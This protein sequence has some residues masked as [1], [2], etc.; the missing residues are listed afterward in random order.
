M[1]RT[2]G[3]SNAAPAWSAISGK[4]AVFP[5]DTPIQRTRQQTNTSGLLTWTFPTPFG[6]G[7]VPVIGVAVES[8]STDSWG[9]VLKSVSNTAVTVQLTRTAAVTILGI[10]VLGIAA[11]PQAYVHLMAVAP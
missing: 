10:S 2:E 9:H 8:G 11:T 1:P 5:S 6:G 3:S 7:V 4:P